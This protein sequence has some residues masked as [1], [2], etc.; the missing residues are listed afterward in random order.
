MKAILEFDLDEPEDRS[1]HKLAVHAEEMR[2]ALDEIWD[3]VFRPNNKHGYNN[4]VLD[5]EEAYHVIEALLDRYQAVLD[6][7]DLPI[8]GS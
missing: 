1:S 4:K 6:E 7:Y 3:K 2:W 8:S 5:S